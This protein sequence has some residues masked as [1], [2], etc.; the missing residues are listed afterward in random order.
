MYQNRF[1]HLRNLNRNRIPEPSNI[2]M[3]LHRNERPESWPSDF[4]ALVRSTSPDHIFERYPDPTIFHEKLAAF[5]GVIP[6]QL[7]ITSGIDE[8]LKTLIML[9]CGEGDE[10]CVP[11]PSYAM[12]KV[13]ADVFGAGFKPIPYFPDEKVTPK[14]IIDALTPKTRILFLPNPNQPVENCFT[15]NEIETIATACARDD[16]ILAVDEA[17]F[18]YGATTCVHLIEKFDNLVVMRTFSKAFGGAGLRL[19]FAVGQERVLGPMKAVRL[20]HE[21][22]SLSINAGILLLDRFNE[23]VEPSIRDICAGRNLVREQCK[24]LGFKTWGSVSNNVLID[25][26]SE[27]TKSNFVTRLEMQGIFVKGNF[28]APMQQHILMACGSA[29]LMSQFMET[30]KAI[31]RSS[32]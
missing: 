22:N 20:A 12:Y 9:A 10:I 15:P 5:V 26:G 4:L 19:G 31:Y 23:F 7:L 11:W 21:C 6:D 27:E 1:Q 8:Q 28:D 2:R 3:R 32:K 14:N 16:I 17:Y 29:A 18:H 13:Y 25:L 24:Q 30:F